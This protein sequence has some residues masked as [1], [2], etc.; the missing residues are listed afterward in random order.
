MNKE[1]EKALVDLHTALAKE[2]TNRVG[3][4]ESTASDLSVA[5]QFLKDNGVDLGKFQ[6]SAIEDLAEKMMD[7]LPDFTEEDNVVTLGGRP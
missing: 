2:L 7:D 3:K 6:G 1:I 5:R 4:A